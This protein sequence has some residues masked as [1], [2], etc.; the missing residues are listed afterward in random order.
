MK[1][2]DLLLARANDMV[3]ISLASLCSSSFHS[4]WD[5]QSLCQNVL[6]DIK[7]L[8][9]FSI[10]VLNDPSHCE[11]VEIYPRP[12]STAKAVELFFY[13]LISLAAE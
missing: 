13:V 2:M 4:P 10:T 5:T 6:D 11:T 8:I 9:P 12:C 7:S 1:A 3:K